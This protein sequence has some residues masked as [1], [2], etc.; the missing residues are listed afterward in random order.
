MTVNLATWRTVIGIFNCRKSA[1][2]SHVCNL[3][4]N[5]VSM[6]EVLLQCWHYVEGASISL[7]TLVYIFVFLQ[8]H[9]DIE[10]NPGPRKP[11]S[12]NFSVCHWN[13]N[14][15]SAHNFTKLTQLKAYN[16]IYKYDFICLS[17]TYLVLRFLI[18]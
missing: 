9:G 14:S 3:T 12:N 16:S 11:K 8:C 5:F 10:L 17:E 13:L 4:K 6:I 15:L 18:I 7:L 1:M 2:C